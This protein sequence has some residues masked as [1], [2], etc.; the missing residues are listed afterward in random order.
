MAAK[1]VTLSLE[2]FPRL[3]P[4]AV[5]RSLGIARGLSA[6]SGLREISA[7]GLGRVRLQ[8]DRIDP[9]PWRPGGTPHPSP[10][11][12]FLLV[13][14]DGSF[15]SLTVERF[16]A[17]SLVRAAL[18]APVPP[19]VRPLSPSERGVLAAIVAAALA[20]G[21]ASQTRISLD[22]W[23]PIDDRERVQVDLSA[24]AGSLSGAVTVEAPV[25]WLPASCLPASWLTSRGGP[26]S[27][28]AL[29][30]LATTVRIELGR[31]SLERR[32]CQAADLGDA[33]VFEG[34]SAVANGGDWPCQVWIGGWRAEGRIAA[35][36]AVRSLGKFD[37]VADASVND[38]TD[39]DDYG[40]KGAETGIDP[41]GAALLAS[42]PVEVTA[43]IGKLTLR[44]DEV[45]GLLAGSVLSLGPRRRDPILLRV[46]GRAWARGELVTV[47]DDLG[48]RIT[49][50]LRPR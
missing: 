49:E 4:L 46:A 2:G 45:M 50:I 33:V 7:R 20:A 18:S 43:E 24:H 30:V 5:V 39:D 14:A 35:D 1:V 47:D 38:M 25:S 9:T 3:P 40:S 29:G 36:G 6:F 44:G 8:V 41:A 17:L 16:F 42:A 28:D 11:S 12:A 26:L 15:G 37:L 34:V 22:P 21:G 19:V 31:T 32:A 48:V 23:R 13:N 27:R 10:E